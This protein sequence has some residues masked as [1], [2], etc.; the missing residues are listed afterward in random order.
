MKEFTAKWLRWCDQRQANL[1]KLNEVRNIKNRISE[2]QKDEEWKASVRCF[3]YFGMRVIT[4]QT[5]FEV[6]PKVQKSNRKI[7]RL[8]FNE[9][10]RRLSR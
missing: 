4:Y 5:A 8:R 9:M 1:E 3:F 10:W 6:L 7:G 2:L